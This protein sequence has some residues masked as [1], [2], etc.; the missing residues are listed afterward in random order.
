MFAPL[1]SIVRGEHDDRV[2]KSVGLRESLKDGSNGV[3]HRQKC[4]VLVLTKRIDACAVL[5]G[6]L[7]GCPNI[8]GFVGHITLAVTGR[9]PRG[10]V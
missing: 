5:Q 4:A 8:R 7:W 3:V 2:I 1:V 10:Q 6:Q 9:P